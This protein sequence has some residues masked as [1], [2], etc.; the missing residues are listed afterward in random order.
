MFYDKLE[1]LCK[2]K[3]TTITAVVVAL[4]LS[5]GNI[6][7][8]KNGSVPKYD[9]R[10]KIANYLEV[11]IDELLTPEE[12]ETRETLQKAVRMASKLGKTSDPPQF[13]EDDSFLVID[14]SDLYLIPVFEGIAAGFGVTAHS[15]PVDY[16]PMKISCKSEV[17]EYLFINVHGD[18]MTPTI[19]DGSQILVKKQ[20]SVDSGQIAAVLI[21]NEEAVVKRVFYGDDWIELHSLNPAYAPMKFKGIEVDRIRILGLVKKVTVDLQ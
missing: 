9:T 4:G 20:E 7:N 11:S 12:L 19:I 5:K 2:E 6:R 13:T 14:D 15:E 10:L 18:S 17:D 16:V 21:D 8:W 1:S 3:N